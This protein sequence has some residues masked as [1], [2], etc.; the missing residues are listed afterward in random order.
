[1][2]IRHSTQHPNQRPIRER[3][4]MTLARCFRALGDWIAQLSIQKNRI[5]KIAWTVLGM[6]L[7]P[8]IVIFLCYS[9][10]IYLD[11]AA[12]DFAVIIHILVMLP[13]SVQIAVDDWGKDT[14]LR[15]CFMVFTLVAIP[16]GIAIIT[17][18]SP[19]QSYDFIQ[20]FLLS[21]SFTVIACVFTYVRGCHRVFYVFALL[22]FVAVALNA[23]Y[24]I[25]I[26]GFPIALPVW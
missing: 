26:H 11:F 25:S 24:Q 8:A 20:G 19:I 6:L 16:L 12:L 1:M 9:K 18:I 5:R 7:M 4:K 17:V 2:I 10:R 13:L 15:D 22:P 3:A 14:N 21:F 23:V